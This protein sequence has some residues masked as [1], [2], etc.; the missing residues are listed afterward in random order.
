MAQPWAICSSVFFVMVCSPLLIIKWAPN[1]GSRMGLNSGSACQPKMLLVLKYERWIKI[2]F[3]P[4]WSTNGKFSGKEEFK[5][6]LLPKKF[7]PDY[8]L[9]V[10][11]FCVY[12]A[13][14]ILSRAKLDFLIHPNPLKCCWVA[15]WA[16]AYF[17]QFS[18]TRSFRHLQHANWFDQQM[19]FFQAHKFEHSNSSTVDGLSAHFKSA[20]LKSVKGLI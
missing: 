17:E 20:L 4:I 1:Y 14:R 19:F 8:H 9:I 5:K 16:H 10:K 12:R 15:V 7:A 3:A 2:S 6:K 18:P 11:Y 13:S